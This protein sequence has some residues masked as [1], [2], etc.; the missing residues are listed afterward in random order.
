MVDALESAKL[1]RSS[2]V[3]GRLS[4][5]LNGGVETVFEQIVV[6]LDSHDFDAF[7]GKAVEASLQLR[8]RLVDVA[9]AGDRRHDPGLFDR[10]AWEPA[11]HRTADHFRCEGLD[12]KRNIDHPIV[13]RLRLDI[14]VFRSAVAGPT[15]ANF[16]IWR[17]SWVGMVQ[18]IASLSTLC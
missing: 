10:D 2:A 6:K 13:R 9:A 5:R 18:V 1:R 3:I 15:L 8:E 11:Y 12:V 14:G 4:V 16:P 7:F 17:R